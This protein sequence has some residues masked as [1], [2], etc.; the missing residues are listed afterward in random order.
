MSKVLDLNVH[1]LKRL[2]GLIFK[3][4]WLTISLICFLYA[5]LLTLLNIHKAQFGH[6]HGWFWFG[7][8]GAIK[9]FIAFSFFYFWGWQLYYFRGQFEKLRIG[10]YLKMYGTYFIIGGT[11][12]WSLFHFGYPSPYDE[13]N[14]LYSK[15]LIK[16][17]VTFLVDMS[18]ETVVVGE[19]EEPAVYLN[20]TPWSTPHGFK[21]EEIENN[22]WIH[23]M[24]LAVGEYT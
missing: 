7:D 9:G 6:I 2:V 21:M 15:F 19:G 23:T 8:H 22:L 3:K 18:T 10:L 4:P 17:K 13:W 14:D 11:L 20:I 12:V 5:T 24:D 16:K 1:H